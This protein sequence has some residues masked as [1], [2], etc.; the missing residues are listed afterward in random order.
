VTADLTELRSMATVDAP[1]PD[2]GELENGARGATPIGD[3]LLLD[4]A[5]AEAA[6][7]GA[8]VASNGGRVEVDD[9]LG[10]ALCDSS[11]PLAFGNMVH[12]LQPLAESSTMR[13]VE[14]VRSFFA[15]G[16]G[17]PYIMFCPWPTPNLHEHGF[18][19]AGHPPLMVRPRVPVATPDTGL[20]IVDVT[21]PAELETFERTLCEAYP[22]PEMLPFGSQRRLFGE[23]ILEAPTHRLFVGYHDDRAVATALAFVDQGVVAVEA[24]ATRDECR[25]R[26]YGAAITAAATAAADH[27]ALLVASDLGRNVY[28][29]LGYMPVLRYT[30]WVG[31]R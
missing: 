12:L 25:G 4:Y 22:S 1:A 8:I 5:R 20:R 21:T 2:E 13:F 3:N 7:Y 14:R 26:G 23:P 11:L 24:V 10:I 9:E 15:A 18:H 30:L 17:G 31:M 29:N 28:A 6:G 27:P 16:S 19:L